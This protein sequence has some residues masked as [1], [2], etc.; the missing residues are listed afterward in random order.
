MP[1]LK[2]ENLAWALKS[3]PERLPLPPAPSTG[4]WPGRYSERPVASSASWPSLVWVA[5]KSALMKPPI[6]TVVPGAAPGVM[7]VTWIGCLPAGTEAT[8]FCPACTVRTSVTACWVWLIWVCCCC[9]EDSS[10]WTWRS[11]SATRASSAFSLAVSANAM[12]G[13]TRATN[14]QAAK[15][16]RTAFNVR[17]LMLPSL[18]SGKVMPRVGH[19]RAET[20]GRLCIAA[21]RHWSNPALL[22]AHFRPWSNQSGDATGGGW[23]KL[24]GI[25]RCDAATAHTKSTC[26]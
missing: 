18:P 8:G 15:G 20:A 25:G 16:V 23:G 6:L 21:I 19:G 26:K 13:A 9:C 3:V 4:V 14:R 1:R 11:S 17:W 5:R 22:G 2:R 7:V 12:P 10:S 24:R